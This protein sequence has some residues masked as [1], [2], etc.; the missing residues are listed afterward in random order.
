LATTGQHTIGGVT[1]RPIGLGCAHFTGPGVWEQP[2][3]RDESLRVLRRALELGVNLFDTADSY[4]P[5]VSEE[6]VHEALYPYPD[7]IVLNTKVGELRAKPSV[8]G[9]ELPAAL[10]RPEY[11]KYALE[12][13][14]RRL[15]VD[16]LKLVHLHR[17][18]PQVPF[19]DSVGALKELQDEGKIGEIGISNVTVAQLEIARGVARIVSVQNLFN[20]FEQ[21]ET[22][23]LER[24]EELGIA[25]LPFFPLAHGKILPGGPFDELAAS[26]GATP[27]QLGL[28][29]LLNRSPAFVPIPGPETVAEL[30]ED[31]GADHFQLSA[32]VLDEATKIAGSQP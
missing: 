10:G 3:D 1:L 24:C 26:V 9:G 30:E 4:G 27:P 23:V 16:H 21:E 32:E 17:P 25:F 11:L 18:D 22:P 6:I 29:W 31:L 12:M 7:D 15:G 28:A 19:E 5:Y 20:L 14:L 13:S 2:L 8:R